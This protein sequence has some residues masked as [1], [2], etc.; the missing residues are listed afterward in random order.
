M[1]LVSTYR[2][3]G[4]TTL[5]LPAFGF[6]SAH[7]DL[8]MFGMADGSQRPVTKSINLQILQSLATIS[9]NERVSDNF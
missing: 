2:Q 3:V 1:N 9:G 6:G 8:V 7:Q 5:K 4:N